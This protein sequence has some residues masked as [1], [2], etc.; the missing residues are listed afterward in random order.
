M[1]KELNDYYTISEELIRELQHIYKDKIIEEKSLCNRIDQLEDEISRMHSFSNF[2]NGTN[3]FKN[4]N[5]LICL[6]KILL[7]KYFFNECKINFPSLPSLPDWFIQPSF[8]TTSFRTKKIELIFW[9]PCHGYKK[10]VRWNSV[11]KLVVWSM[12]QKRKVM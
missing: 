5:F 9:Q 6:W 1:E 12:P 7:L 2:F 4:T 8:A 11:G 3:Q 10:S